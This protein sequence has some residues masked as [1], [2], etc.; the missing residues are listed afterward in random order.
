MPEH[1]FQN[2]GDFTVTLTVTDDTHSVSSCTTL[3]RVHCVFDI[4]P[5][6]KIEPYNTETQVG[7]DVVFDGSNSSGVCRDIVWYEWDF[8]DG[9]SATGVKVA[10]HYEKPGTF[11]VTL[12][13]WDEDGGASTCLVYVDVRSPN[14]VEPATWGRIKSQYR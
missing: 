12:T 9:A 10:H 3:A 14:P 11:V 13:V 8:G 6:C 2:L 1:Q 7:V 4:Y 5:L